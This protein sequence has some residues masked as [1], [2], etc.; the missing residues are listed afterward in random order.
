MQFLSE[1][2]KTKAITSKTE[3]FVVGDYNVLIFF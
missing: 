2:G 1:T 3:G